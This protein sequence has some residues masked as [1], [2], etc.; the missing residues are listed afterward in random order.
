MR[1][2]V[3]GRAGIAGV[4][5]PLLMMAILPGCGGDR[6]GGPSVS[7]HPVSGKVVLADGKPLTGGTIV[8][9][10]TGP[11]MMG[12]SGTI[13]P[14]GTFRLSTYGADDGAGAGD[15]VARIE[16]PASANPTQ[17]A[18][19]LFPPQF[20]DESTSGL[21]IHIESSTDQLPPIELK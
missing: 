5:L 4:A 15:Y 12:A 13:G 3:T 21:K 11:D 19:D 2:R 8:L 10:P 7:V 17:K 9:L 1:D 14:D 6:H 16:P 20:K 18:P